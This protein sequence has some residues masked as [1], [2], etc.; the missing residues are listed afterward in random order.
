MPMRATIV[1]QT[2]IA[3]V[4]CYEL[5]PGR[6]L[7]A[8]RVMQGTFRD[9]EI[10]C[11]GLKFAGI[12]VEVASINKAGDIALFEQDW[13]PGLDDCP[14]RESAHPSPTWSDLNR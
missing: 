4:F 13:K 12:P 9:C 1:Y 11:H 5:A 2:G 3:N 7:L 14:F 8:R 6:S 10:F